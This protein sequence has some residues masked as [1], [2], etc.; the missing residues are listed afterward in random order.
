MKNGNTDYWVSGDG[1]KPHYTSRWCQHKHRSFEA[2]LE[3]GQRRHEL[4]KVDPDKLYNSPT[5]VAVLKKPRKEHLWVEHQWPGFAW[6]FRWIDLPN[7]ELL[8]LRKKMC[9]QHRKRTKP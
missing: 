5:A 3:C 8:L 4:T 9:K 6:S 7:W 2:A 1:Q